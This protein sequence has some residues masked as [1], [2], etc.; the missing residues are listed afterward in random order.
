MAGFSPGTRQGSRNQESK[1]SIPISTTTSP[2]DLKEI[3]AHYKLLVKRNLK[4]YALREGKWEL[5][6][7]DSDSKPLRGK[8]TQACSNN[9]SEPRASRHK[10]PHARQSLVYSG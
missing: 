4:V 10:M 7:N 3:F 9:Q 6:D 8:V 5:L 2:A 1:L